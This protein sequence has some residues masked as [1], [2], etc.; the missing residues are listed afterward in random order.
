[1]LCEGKSH[2]KQKIFNV[3]TANIHGDSGQKTFAVQTTIH[4]PQSLVWVGLKEC[5]QW[6]CGTRPL[7]YWSQF[8]AEERSDRQ[9][10]T[11]ELAY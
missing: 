8:S 11:K 10:A 9:N 1:M 3:S 5:K 6:V 4:K 7:N 2:C